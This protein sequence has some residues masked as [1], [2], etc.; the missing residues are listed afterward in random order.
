MVRAWIVIALLSGATAR[1]ETHCRAIA[2]GS[3]KLESIDANERLAFLRDALR[4]GARHA[5]IYHWGW[6]AIYAGLTAYNG[7]RIASDDAYNR[8]NDYFGTGASAF[9]LLVLWIAP[10]KVM[11]DQRW[12]ERRLSRAPPDE[13]RC[14]QLADAE[15]LLLRDAEGEAFGKSALIHI[16]N[17][18]F[19]TGLALVL[20]IG[21][22]HWDQAAIQGLVGV[23]VGELQS[24]TQPSDEIVTLARYR[25]ADL[26]REPDRALRWHLWA[27]PLL[28]EQGAIVSAGV[29]F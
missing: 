13:D 6:T 14:A 24:F 29:N 11:R 28:R 12:L 22:G 15:R 26:R 4:R 21:F 23:A 27:A 3:L 10:L 8:I 5:R 20:G 2:G 18:A 9:G 1:A 17:F 7:G 16:G 25:R 19:N